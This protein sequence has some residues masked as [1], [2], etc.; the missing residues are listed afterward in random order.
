MINDPRPRCLSLLSFLFPYLERLVKSLVYLLSDMS[1]RQTQVQGANVKNMERNGGGEA[2]PFTPHQHTTPKAKTKRDEMAAIAQKEAEQYAKYKEGRKMKHVKE[3]PQ[4]TG[5]AAGSR[6]Q[7]L[8]RME[9]DI[10]SS[11]YREKVKRDMYKEEQK[12]VEDAEINKKLCAAR[13][14][15]EKNKEKEKVRE[16]TCNVRRVEE[17][18]LNRL[19]YFGKNT[20]TQ[21]APA[22]QADNQPQP[23]QSP[24]Q[25]PQQPIG[26]LQSVPSPQS[27]DP[28]QPSTGL[29]QQ[30]QQQQQHPS[31]ASSSDITELTTAFPLIDVEVLQD[32]YT[33]SNNDLQATILLLSEQ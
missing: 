27:S 14:Q 13:L 19:K 17:A 25:Q 20:M 18:R 8:R 4:C 33:S 6:E 7:A 3:E 10:K 21:P 12:R 31:S 9:N 16:E 30:Q 1:S 26:P 24:Q 29:Q 11:K 32:I 2:S 23:P 5:G 15:A 22:A 28:S